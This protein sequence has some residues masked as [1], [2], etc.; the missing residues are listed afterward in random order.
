MH[1][2]STYLIYNHKKLLRFLRYDQFIFFTKINNN[3]NKIN[4]FLTSLL[5]LKNKEA[6]SSITS[7]FVLFF[8]ST[9]HVFFFFGSSYLFYNFLKCNICN[10]Y[11]YIYLLEY[12]IR[13]ITL[14]SL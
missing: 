7:H 9:I 13:K 6:A 8:L 1:T 5:Y 2:Y 12:L 4:I 14:Y 10:P 11:H 3:R